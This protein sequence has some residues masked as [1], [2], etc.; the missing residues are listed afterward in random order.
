MAGRPDPNSTSP[1]D[2]SFLN[3]LRNPADDAPT[4]IEATPA[5]VPQFTAIPPADNAPVAAVVP[6][7]SATPK[8]QP[9]IT[10]GRPANA[11]AATIA[12]PRQPAWLPGYAVAVTLLLILLA[13][14]GRISLVSGSHPLESL[15][16][17]RPLQP[18]EFQIIP[19]DAPLPPMH[20]LKLNESRR[21]GDVILT[22]LRVSREPLTFEHFQTHTPEPRLTSKPVLK[23]WLQFKNVSRD[24]AFLPYDNSLMSH[25]HPMFATDEFTQANSGLNL[26]GTT[27]APRILNFLHPALSNLLLTGQHVD[28]PVTPGQTVEVFV[29]SAELPET[30]LKQASW[31]WRIQFRKGVHQPS[32]NGVTTL[33]DVTFDT[34]EI[35]LAEATPAPK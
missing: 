5:T 7:E 22:P 34:S 4:P 24:Y 27:N 9:A 13:I 3:Q 20:G 6:P 11:P 19:P 14:T 8:L 33:V 10:P 16:D 30:E 21:F 17:V 32:G 31:T 35:L 25:R 2:F 29:A 15:P 12:A 23:L 1:Q 18:G 28:T 26:A